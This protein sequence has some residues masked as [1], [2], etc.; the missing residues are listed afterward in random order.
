MLPSSLEE[1]SSQAFENS[2]L[3]SLTFEENSSLKII[4]RNAF[5]NCLLQGTLTLP[6]SLSGIYHN[7]FSNNNLEKV[8]ISSSTSV[9]YNSFDN[10]V[11]ITYY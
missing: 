11:E 8:N 7:A 4:S 3:K 10:N 9:D 6:S 1:I 2:K 5:Y